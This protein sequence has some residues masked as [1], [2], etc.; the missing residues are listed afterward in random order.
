MAARLRARGSQARR[1]TVGGVRRIAWLRWVVDGGRT[2]AGGAGART[3][4]GAR[5]EGR[6]ALDGVGLGLVAVRRQRDVGD[7]LVGQLVDEGVEAG[8]ELGGVE[9]AARGLDLAGSRR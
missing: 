8:D 2:R 3:G 6:A 4:G 1:E 7:W 9:R 5:G